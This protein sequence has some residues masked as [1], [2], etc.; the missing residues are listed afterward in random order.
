[1]TI[2]WTTMSMTERP[3]QSS[4]WT[5][6]RR[7]TAHS[8]PVACSANF[9][10]RWNALIGSAASGFAPPCS[11]LIGVFTAVV[12]CVGVSQVLFQSGGAMLL[13]LWRCLRLPGCSWS[14]E[15][16]QR[17]FRS[18]NACRNDF[19]QSALSDARARNHRS[20]PVQKTPGRAN[21]H[22]CRVRGRRSGH[23]R[24]DGNRRTS[25]HCGSRHC[26]GAHY[27]LIGTNLAQPKGL[28]GHRSA[29]VWARAISARSLPCPC[30]VS[31]CGF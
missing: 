5:R 2:S 16:P 9:S 23:R 14:G 4:A 11:R 8:L 25:G 17:R 21:L 26:R 20:T 18:H 13:I 1:M 6:R 10:G 24:D 3:S 30:P 29:L 22:R 27:F 12:S 15:G 31:P 19:Q 28:A 7:R